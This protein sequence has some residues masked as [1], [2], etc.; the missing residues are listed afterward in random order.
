MIIRTLTG[1]TGDGLLLTQVG[2]DNL[3]PL[4]SLRR[5]LYPIMTVLTL[6]KTC[7]RYFD[8]VDLFETI[9][10]KMS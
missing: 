2:T 5:V 9:K 4:E 6:P 8:L 3:N 1:C 10:T 7:Q